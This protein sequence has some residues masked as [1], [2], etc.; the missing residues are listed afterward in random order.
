MILTTTEGQKDLP[1][2]FA[3]AYKIAKKE[4]ALTISELE[5]FNVFD[6]NKYKKD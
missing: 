2:Y 4:R 6:P 3:I 1:R 5:Y